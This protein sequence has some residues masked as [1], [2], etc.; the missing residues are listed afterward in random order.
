ME[1]R[2][3]F[4]RIISVCY[5]ITKND[6]NLQKIHPARRPMTKKRVRSFLELAN[7]YR[8][9]NSSFAVIAAPLSDLTCE[10][11]ASKT[12]TKKNFWQTK[13]TKWQTKKKLL[14]TC[15]NARLRNQ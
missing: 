12:E 10:A 9:Y 11:L 2:V 15:D 4:L 6:D 14:S 1:V 5:W 13:K 7:Y 8:D 3:E